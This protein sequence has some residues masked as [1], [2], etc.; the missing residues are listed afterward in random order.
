MHRRRIRKI[1]QRF[2]PLCPV[3]G[4][5]KRFSI[6][7]EFKV[8]GVCLIPA[9]MAK[10]SRDSGPTRF[11]ARCHSRE[12]RQ[13][14][15]AAGFANDRVAAINFTVQKPYLRSQNSPSSQ[16]AEMT[17]DIDDHRV[18]TMRLSGSLWRNGPSLGPSRLG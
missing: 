3:E 12:D 14:L 2:R 13:R 9:I 11:A 1:R 5:V 16:A 17:S 10:F 18:V 7:H 6:R 8:F 15:I 4:T